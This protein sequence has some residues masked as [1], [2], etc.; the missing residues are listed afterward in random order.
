L[1]LPQSRL[2]IAI[3]SALAGIYAVYAVIVIARAGYETGQVLA[4][5]ISIAGAIARLDVSGG[6]LVLGGVAVFMALQK[7]PMT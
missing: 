4:G 5:R 1:P 3:I 7:R 2:Q 6:L